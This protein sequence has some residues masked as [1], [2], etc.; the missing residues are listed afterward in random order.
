MKLRDNIETERLVGVIMARLFRL[1]YDAIDVTSRLIL[2]PTDLSA[3]SRSCATY[4]VPA[5]GCLQAS[6]ELVSRD[7]CYL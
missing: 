7:K 1:L 6:H 2:A 5:P 4:V 3:T